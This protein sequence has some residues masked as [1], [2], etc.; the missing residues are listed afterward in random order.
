MLSSRNPT[1]EILSPARQ[2]LALV[3]LRVKRRTVFILDNNATLVTIFPTSDLIDAFVAPTALL[4][5][6]A[7]STSVPLDYNMAGA[8]AEGLTSA[9]HD[10][11]RHVC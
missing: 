11:M 4:A 7:H 3:K 8:A 5:V 9:L 1:F 6:N 10:N 2:Y